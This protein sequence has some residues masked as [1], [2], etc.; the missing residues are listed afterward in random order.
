MV[1]LFCGYKYTQ[2][3]AD[4]GKRNGMTLNQQRC[5]IGHL[6]GV[7]NIFAF[8]KLLLY[9]YTSYVHTHNFESSISSSI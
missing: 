4:L 8:Y 5:P 1:L 2:N 3:A 7:I 6:G 9:A